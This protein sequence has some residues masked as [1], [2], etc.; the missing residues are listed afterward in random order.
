MASRHKV[1]HSLAPSTRMDS[2]NSL[3]TSRMK[4]DR[5]RTESG[6]AK[7]MD[8]RMIASRL[9]YSLSLMMIR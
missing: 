5:T 7:A 9:S 1:V 3:G 4:F 2:N 8:G 6:M